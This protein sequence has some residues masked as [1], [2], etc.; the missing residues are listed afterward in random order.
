MKL[1]NRTQY[2]K[3]IKKKISYHKKNCKEYNNFLSARKINLNKI[4]TLEKIPFIHVNM[5]K[6][7][8]L[9][10][11]KKDKIFLQ[12]NSSGTTGNKSKVFLS[13]KNSM[14]QKN[15]LKKILTDEFGDERLPFIFLDQNPIFLKDRKKLG[16][17]VA[18]MLGFSL[19]GK[20]FFY[21][22]D[23]NNKIDYEGLNNFLEL[24]YKKKFIIFGF[25]SSVYDFLI[26]KVDL[27]KIKYPMSNSTII[28]GGGWKKLLDRGISNNTLKAKL[29]RR[30][31]IKKVINY[32]GFVEQTGSIFLECPEFG[33]FH[34]NSV[35]DIFIRDKDLKLTNLN[36]KGILQCLSIVPSSYPGNSI[37]LED[38]AIFKGNNCK[39]GRPGK[40][41]TVQGR[42]A[43]T[44]I[45][46]CSDFT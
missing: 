44:E 40:I 35:S 16:A 31:E 24:F 15:F 43:K 10:S 3:E 42:L 23:K 7:Y 2:L 25:T 30:F 1:E 21:I 9:L 41:F 8:D 29:N 45:R 14:D 11:V 5:F 38:E 26:N 13:K 17:K 4:N 22:I 27:K 37:L 46:G 34:T 36:E 20:N 32:F 12:L 18:A 28:H 33:N 6:E 39:C 19:I